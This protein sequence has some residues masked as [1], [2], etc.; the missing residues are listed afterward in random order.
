ML[1]NWLCLVGPST[2][3]WQIQLATMA[4]A[5]LKKQ[6]NKAN[7]VST[8]KRERLSLS[9][10]LSSTPSPSIDPAPAA[11]GSSNMKCPTVS[12]PSILLLL[13]LFRKWINVD[14]KLISCSFFVAALLCFVLIYDDESSKNWCLDVPNA[15]SSHLIISVEETSNPK[16][17]PGDVKELILTT[18]M[19][20]TWII[21]KESPPQNLEEIPWITKR[22]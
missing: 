18:S 12:D 9:L 21:S 10:S 17:W 5:G 22:K 20:N 15:S 3:R 11:V 19:I 1:V 13:L 2:A 8:T 4:F 14:R 7:Q 6:I 16:T